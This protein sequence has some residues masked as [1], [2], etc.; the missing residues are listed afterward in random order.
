MPPHRPLEEP[1]LLGFVQ[2]HG[3]PPNMAM[4]TVHCFLVFSTVGFLFSS[5]IS[6]KK[7]TLYFT[8][9]NVLRCFEGFTM[10]YTSLLD[11]L[12]FSWLDVKW[13]W[14]I[15]TKFMFKTG[16]SPRN[17]LPPYVGRTGKLFPSCVKDQIVATRT[18]VLEETE[19]DFS[20]V[21]ERL[22]QEILEIFGCSWRDE[23]IDWTVIETA[24]L[25]IFYS[26]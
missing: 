2:K 17:P 26:Q 1:R 21:G 13:Q 24:C 6:G 23:G 5:K 9:L 8:V 18:D 15:P 16:T 11:L 22:L 7:N 19:C 10:L 4:F 14:N 25:V 20:V 12:S 3:V